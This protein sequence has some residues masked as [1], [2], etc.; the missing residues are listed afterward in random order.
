[1]QV[2]EAKLV[3]VCVMFEKSSSEMNES[4]SKQPEIN[5]LGNF[6]FFLRRLCHFA[7]PFC[8][9]PGRFRGTQVGFCSDDPPSL[10]AY[11][12]L[13]IVQQIPEVSDDVAFCT[14]MLAARKCARQTGWD[15]ARADGSIVIEENMGISNCLLQVEHD[16]VPT[17]G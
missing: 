6:R 7:G 5:P 9:S 15:L 12:I 4:V 8:P 3:A 11:K 1:M 13:R 10:S 2:P 14:P 16:E 17:A